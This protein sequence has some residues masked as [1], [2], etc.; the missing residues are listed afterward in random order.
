MT[1]VLTVKFYALAS[2]HEPVRDWLRE[3]D[4]EI[5]KVVGEDIKTVQMGW[6][7]GMPLVRKLESG[8]WEVRSHIPDGI[9]RVLFTTQG[10]KMLLL[11]GFVKKSDKTPK[12]DIALARRRKKDI[13]HEE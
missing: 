2:G 9:V 7:I 4:F 13:D 12:S 11:H 10:A 1:P 5:R 6:P 3:Q 8:L